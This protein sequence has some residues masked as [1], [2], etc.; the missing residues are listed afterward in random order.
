MP[1]KFRYYYSSNNIGQKQ[2][3]S[4]ISIPTI[5]PDSLFGRERLICKDVELQNE[6]VLFLVHV[7]ENYN[8]NNV[9]TSIIVGDNERFVN[10]TFDSSGIDT[11]NTYDM[12]KE[13]YSKYE[14]KK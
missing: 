3:P 5:D 10:I 12:F 6:E 9:D 4:S 2:L 8:I 13:K 1:P 11:Q 14:F 7:C